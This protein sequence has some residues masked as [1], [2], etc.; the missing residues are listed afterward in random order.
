MLESW[1]WVAFGKNEGLS[2]VDI[3]Q[4][5]ETGDGTV[6]VSTSNGPQWYDGYRWQS[7]AGYP[8]CVAGG[9]SGAGGT[10]S[11]PTQIAPFGQAQIL[12]ARSKR[13]YRLS[14]TG[15]EALDPR[16]KGKALEILSA[17]TSRRGAALAVET[18]LE[19][20]NSIKYVWD[21]VAPDL[22]NPLDASGSPPVSWL[23]YGQESSNFAVTR[24]AMV[25]Y[26][27]GG[28]LS[29]LS[30]KQLAN[31]A[32]IFGT[33]I[34]ALAE[35]GAGQGLLSLAFP[36]EW[37]SLWE[38]GPGREL[39][40]VS[41]KA[42]QIAR[43]LAVAENGDA[44]A[45]YNSQQVWIREGRAW[46]ALSPI[47]MPLR[48]AKALH[49]D[50]RGRL[51]VASANGLNLLRL[52]QRRW[53]KLSFPFPDLK[54][55]LVAILPAKDG[56]L[57]IGTA[58]GAIAVGPDNQLDNSFGLTGQPP[59]V[60]T[61]LAQTP[62]GV[63]WLSS[64]AT[65]TGVFRLHGKSVK[66]YGAAQGLADAPI[67]KL[68]VD[69]SGA[70]W[71]LATGAGRA[72]Q[73]IGVHRFDGQRFHLW[74]HSSGLIDKRVYSLVRT[75]DG[76]LWFATLG[77]MSSF[78]NGAWRHWTQK[79][80]LLSDKLFFVAARPG[81]GVYFLDR[82]NGLGEIG[83]DGQPRY[84]RI[85]GSSATNSA[86]E[87]T[88]EGSNDL[89][90]A[91]RGGLFLRRD[92]E[93]NWI[94]QPAGLDNQELWP[95]ALWNN[96]VC[97][98]SDGSGLFCLDRGVLAGPGP[99]VEFEPAHIDGG[100]VRAQW[101][102][103]QFEDSAG[104]EGAR[105]RYRVDAQPWSAWGAR[106][107]VSVASLAPGA[108]RLE[109][110]AKD[111]FGSRAVKAGVLEFTV[112]AAFYAQP[113]FLIPVGVSLGA[114]LIAILAFVS[115][116][117]FHNRQLA[118][119]EE[120]FRALLEYSSI[121]IT[122]RDRNQRVFYVSPAINA[123]LGYEPEELI[124]DYRQ[125]IL[126]PDDVPGAE[127][128]ARAL[129]EVPG[130]TLRSRV[131]MRHK[132]G[133]YRWIEVTARNLLQN[134]AVGAIVN[135]FRDV[136]DSTQAEITASEARQRAEH[137]NLAKS[138][139]LAMISHE[140]RTPM[141]GITGMC[142]L[143]LETS[144][145]AEQL[146]YAETIAQSAQSLLA[147]VNDVLDFSR[148]EAGK[149]SIER[150]PIH[151]ESLVA[152]V[153]QLMRVRAD[154][155]R[156][157]LL[158]H[159]PADAPRGFYGDP[160]RIRQIL[161]NLVGNAVKFTAEGEIRIEVAVS[162]LEAS[163]YMVS[164]E[165]SDTGIGIPPDKLPLIFEKFTQA[166]VSTTR[167]YGGSGLGLTI[168]RSLTELM[169]GTITTSSEAGIGSRFRLDL[170]MDAAPES[171][172]EARD[173]SRQA[174]RPLSEPL[175]ILLV[176]DNLVNQKLAVRLLERLGCEVAVAASGIEALALLTDT[177]Y[178]MVL[179][180]CQM[181]DMDGYETTRQIR[182]RERG[183]KHL[184]IVAITANAMESDLERCISSGMDSY[185]TKPIDF[186]KLRDALEKWGIDSRAP[187]ATSD[188]DA[189]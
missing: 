9:T 3:L 133:E 121:G 36:P 78:R 93:W 117:V 180:D 89:W 97:A 21:G 129:I 176:E 112:P 146:D 83:P 81:G 105:S 66:R 147:L 98:G 75:S 142:Q 103:L 157:R 77:G 19:T 183:S 139:F 70:L 169:G 5:V 134:P 160:L 138:D 92:G 163:R 35:N 125:E 101:R 79:E 165:V 84:T 47:P 154:Q 43:S 91:T 14:R 87:L 29:L 132:N 104:Q 179:M 122:L 51:W 182:S 46:T 177:D 164:I 113:L 155:K 17:S 85:G 59:A 119:K 189:F 152:D 32:Q 124:G 44:V 173:T 107:S 73:Q 94:G 72:Q 56:S 171:A 55:H 166:D 130:Q 82:A 111:Q 136:T 80:G 2:N 40:R 100:S 162:Y 13:L 145:N 4:I 18:L 45:F 151:M 172:I 10:E 60:L 114:A 96:H 187:K 24:E 158:T 123:I 16:A 156:L 74:E 57:K 20:P 108:H 131:R 25:R 65:F 37:A 149:L 90:L 128:S 86:W 1:R 33:T 144:L 116:K 63:F 71:T 127:A 11:S 174:L 69:S 141:N 39:T 41:A 48:T 168:C 170:P 175:S 106:G 23:S 88:L 76:T 61:G 159:Y 64:G 181:P 184:P 6:W 50:S 143:L 49:F 12:A 58:G 30:S 110:D 38:W 54:N 8:A 178:D 102:I 62:D 31:P 15:C 53:T 150:A 148:I 22:G 188:R 109:V 68:I 167:R 118:E 52:D 27:G 140:I 67:H 99:K 7:V 95:V 135:N 161:I 115:R 137:A 120:R 26:V 42:A 126:H 153:A 186:V 34:R 185:L 28:F